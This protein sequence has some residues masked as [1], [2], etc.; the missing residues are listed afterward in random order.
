MGVVELAFGARDTRIASALVRLAR[1]EQGPTAV[2]YAILVSG[3]AAA[4]AG[5]VYVLG[6]RVANLFSR[7]GENWP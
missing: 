6:P 1:D 2:E 4:I 3:I 5:T 7:A